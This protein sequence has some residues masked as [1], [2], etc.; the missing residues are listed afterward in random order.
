MTKS[1]GQNDPNVTSLDE[2]RRRAA[3][4]AKAE[5]RAD[6][7]RSANSVRDWVIGGI[8]VAMAIGFIASFFVSGPRDVL[9]V[10]A[11]SAKTESAE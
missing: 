3:Q 1:N 10:P 2:A 7:A 11:A 4:K 9:D 5:P 6:G 8:I